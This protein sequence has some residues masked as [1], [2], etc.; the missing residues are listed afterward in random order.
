MWSRAGLVAC[1]LGDPRSSEKHVAKEIHDAWIEAPVIYPRSKADPSDIL[2]LAR[3]AGEWGG[4]YKV[5]VALVRYVE[6]AEWKGQLPKDVCHARMWL[7]LS[8]EEKAIVDAACRGLAPSKRHNVL[9]AVA[10]GVWV[11][12]TGRAS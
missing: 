4:I 6:P 5:L 11:R 7:K 9:D 1:G 2:K 8:E 3:D 12:A 10:I